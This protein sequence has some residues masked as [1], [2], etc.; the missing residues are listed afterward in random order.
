MDEKIIEFIESKE[1]IVIDCMNHLNI[2][3]EFLYDT[4]ICALVDAIFDYDPTDDPNQNF[5]LYATYMVLNNIKERIPRLKR[6][7]NLDY[8]KEHIHADIE[9]IDDPF[10]NHT[11]FNH[12]ISNLYPDELDIIRLLKYGFQHSEIAKL[13]DVSIDFLQYKIKNFIQKIKDKVHFIQ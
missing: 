8:L 13:L 10:F 12:L 5:D 2:T 11:A 3:D 4:G 9:T 6:G 1:H 7:S